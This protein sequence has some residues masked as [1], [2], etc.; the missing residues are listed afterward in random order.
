MLCYDSDIRNDSVAS[1][2]IPLSRTGTSSATGGYVVVPERPSRN[3]KSTSWN[4]EQTGNIPSS[5]IV[6]PQNLLN[7][8]LCI[9]HVLEHKYWAIYCNVLFSPQVTVI[10]FLS[11]F[12]IWKMFHKSF[13]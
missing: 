9:L 13:W 12:Q 5:Y 2:F 8:F 7:E 10:D 6:L 1:Q 4:D 3:E 11:V